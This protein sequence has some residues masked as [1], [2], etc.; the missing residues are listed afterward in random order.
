MTEVARVDFSTSSDRACET[1]FGRRCRLTGGSRH[2]GV[3]I[4]FVG[5]LKGVAFLDGR[6]GRRMGIDDKHNERRTTELCRLT[7]PPE[8]P[9]AARRMRMRLRVR[10][11][12]RETSAALFF[13]PR[14][15]SLQMR[16]SNCVTPPIFDDVTR[17]CGSSTSCGDFDAP[18][19]A[20]RQR[21]PVEWLAQGAR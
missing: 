18:N 5:V 20:E 16:L 13:S 4:A 3:R 10:A 19:L 6:T 9:M 11:N 1:R 2:S 8:H 21:W 7:E 17:A 15:Q 12:D 14:P